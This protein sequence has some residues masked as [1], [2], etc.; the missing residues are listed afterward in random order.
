MSITD[1]HALVLRRNTLQR[2]IAALVG[3]ILAAAA[4]VDFANDVVSFAQTGT[5]RVILPAKSGSTATSRAST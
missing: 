1:E 4:L 5:Y 3:W 2:Q